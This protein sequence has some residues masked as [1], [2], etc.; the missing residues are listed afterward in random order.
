MGYWSD[1][2]LDDAF[3]PILHYSDTPILHLNYPPA[4]AYSH[5]GHTCGTEFTRI[6]QPHSVQL[7]TGSPNIPRTMVP[8]RRPPQGPVPTPVRLLIMAKV[9]APA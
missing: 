9:L 4:R 2:V 7:V 1:G 6:G 5:L 8:H 3:K